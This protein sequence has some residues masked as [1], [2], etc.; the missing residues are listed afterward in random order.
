MEAK[1]PHYKEQ[2]L[3]VSLQV[4]VQP[5]NLW[6]P[7]AAHCPGHHGDLG[8]L[9]MVNHAQLFSE[10]TVKDKDPVTKSGSLW[11]ALHRAADGTKHWSSQMSTAEV[12]PVP[13]GERRQQSN[14]HCL[15]DHSLVKFKYI[16]LDESHQTRN[17]PWCCKIFIEA[18][19][20]KVAYGVCNPNFSEAETGGL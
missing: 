1:D 5:L 13:M 4:R 8:K 7:L 16:P 18:K 2:C 10:A 20:K 15:K 12:L 3:Q 14:W 11:I 6:L 17:S 19:K 9:C